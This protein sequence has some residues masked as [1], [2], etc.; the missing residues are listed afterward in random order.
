MAVNTMDKLQ[1]L[2]FINLRP[3]QYHAAIAAFRDGPAYI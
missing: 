1:F 2:S 3:N